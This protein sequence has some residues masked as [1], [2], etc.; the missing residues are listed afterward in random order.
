MITER[1]QSKDVAKVCGKMANNS[2]FSRGKRER[3]Q[4]GKPATSFPPQ[5]YRPSCGTIA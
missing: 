2:N 5:L 1:N 3:N 4:R